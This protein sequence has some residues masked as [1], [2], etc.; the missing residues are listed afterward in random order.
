M[1][2]LEGVL[3]VC[4]CRHHSMP[5]TPLSTKTDSTTPRMRLKLVLEGDSPPSSPIATTH[6]EL[7]TND[8][9]GNVLYPHSTPITVETTHGVVMEMSVLEEQEAELAEQDMCLEER[10][11]RET[12]ERVED[13]LAYIR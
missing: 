10:L 9:H 11:Q 6:L 7:A 13:R 4:L 12:K 1:C 3:Y 2:V 8:T 5:N